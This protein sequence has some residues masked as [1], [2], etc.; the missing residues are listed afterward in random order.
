MVR[1]LKA[2]AFDLYVPKVKAIHTKI[3]P[4]QACIADALV[5]FKI[6]SRYR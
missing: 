1:V 2:H 6:Y 5:M 3:G 4:P